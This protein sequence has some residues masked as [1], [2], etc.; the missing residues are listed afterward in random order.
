MKTFPGYTDLFISPVTGLILIPDKQSLTDD[1]IWVGNRDNI[2]IESP[3]LIDIKLDI[4][5][6]RKRL[7]Y[8][9]FIIQYPSPHFYNAQALSEVNNGLISNLNGVIVEATLTENYFWIGDA[10]NRPVETNIFPIGTLPDLPYQNIWIGDITNRPVANQRI[11]LINLPPFLSA[12]PVDPLSVPP[13]APVNFGLYNIYTGGLN[14]SLSEPIAPTTTLKIDKS[15]L[16]NLSKGKIWMGVI[17]VFPPSISFIPTPPYVTIVGDLNWDVRGAL[18][19]IGD[20][21]AVPKEIGLDPGTIF[22]GDFLNPGQITQTGLDWGKM[23]IGN[24]FGQITTVGLLANQLFTGNIDNSGKIAVTTVLNIVNLPDLT[25]NK[26]WV[27]NNTNR[28]VEGTLPQEALPDL[29]MGNIWIGD[30]S[31]RP[32]PNPTIDITN[33]PN[34]LLNRFWVGNGTARPV[35]LPFNIQTGGGLSGGPIT[36]GTGTISMLPVG[37]AGLYQYATITTN[38][39]GQVVTAIS[40]IDTIEDMQDNIA[41]NTSAINTINTTL[42]DP[43]TG[44]VTTVGLLNVAVFAPVTGLLVV[45]GGLSLQVSNNTEKINEIID[46]SDAYI[47]QIEENTTNIANNTSLIVGIIAGTTPID[48]NFTAIGDVSG[49]G[50]LSSDITLTLNTPLNNVPIATGNIDVNNYKIIN[51][52]YPEDPMDAANKQYVDDS[53]GGINDATYIIQTTDPGLTNAQV[54]ADLTTGI[55][56]NT[57]TTG[58]LSIA[59][60]RVDYY[61]PTYPTTIID[62]SGAAKNFG[63]GLN[64]FSSLTIGEENTLVGILT[65]NSIT[66]GGANTCIGYG[67]GFDIVD[68]NSNTGLGH[69]T[70]TNMESGDGNTAVGRDALTTIER[71]D[72]NTALGFESGASFVDY[73]HCLFLGARADANINN[74]TNAIAI[75][76]NTIVG[77]SNSLVLGNGVNVGI[78]T[79]TPTY[80]L[81]VIGTINGIWNGSIIDL[82]HGGTNANLT[83]SNG[84]I[85]YSTS[86]ALAISAAPVVN[87]EILMG[88]VGSAPVWSNASYPSTIMPNQLLY[89]SALNVISGLPTAANS[90]LVTDA[91][92]NISFSTTLPFTVPV[93]TGGTGNTTFSPFSVICAGTISTSPFQGVSGVGALGQVLTS[94]GPSALPTWQTPTLGTVTSVSGTLNQITVTSPTTTPVISIAPTYIGQS[95]I[96][97]LGTITTG[98]WNGSIVDLQYGGTGANLTPSA[99]SIVYSTGTALALSAP[100]GA[101]KIFMSGTGTAPVWSAAVYPAITNPSQLLY[102]SGANNVVGLA[103]ANNATLMTNSVGIPAWQTTSSNFVT[104]ITGTTN[105]ITASAS[106]GA[107]TLSLPASVVITTSLQ[108]GNLQLT[109]NT[110]QSTNSNGNILITPNGTGI[111][112]FTNNV[113]FGTATPNSQIQTSNSIVNRILTLYEQNNNSHEFYGFGINAGI[114]RYQVYAGAS[115]VWYV[116]TSSTTSTEVM[117]GNIVGSSGALGVGGITPSY[118]GDFNGPLRSKRLFGNGNAPSFSVLSGAGTGATAS[119]AGSE[120]AGQITLTLGTLPAGGNVLQLTLSSA[121]PDTNYSI[122][123]QPTNQVTVQMTPWIV[124]NSTTQSTIVFPLSILSGGS[125]MKWRYLIVGST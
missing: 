26:V 104:S 45:V 53:I 29:A 4:I 91:S 67:S 56:F 33:L 109:G 111:T 117:R 110:L 71:G 49:S 25:F 123:L 27:G 1:Y 42:F 39:F 54:L 34:L 16:P 125:I 85:V 15:N 10:S 103:T 13:G 35:A 6:L 41:N 32:V 58:V 21:Y 22:M 80:T 78:G 18:P 63:I 120:V 30:A 115:H 59:I 95:S 28:P 118:T 40:N 124:I 46:G 52:A 98:T 36:N 24:G 100:T 88:R 106:T 73:T 9:P 108:A 121:M 102:S 20:S 2:A 69:T 84:A 70:L 51:L 61:A 107:I 37:T 82:D 3:A 113:G 47:S 12:L 86:S 79:S 92:G 68:G 87:N 65:L 114:L 23:F 64:C 7:N 31:N 74:L 96:T 75:G 17:N 90:T 50:P 55:V 112:S 72:E 60:P 77:A 14:L 48:A 76:Y 116:S 38:T 57:T 93:S 89:G 122:V 62:T 94:V 119:I 11:G 8:T 44:L 97:T 99:G 105:Q 19:I 5:N 81:D 101:N 66:E 43:V 83:A